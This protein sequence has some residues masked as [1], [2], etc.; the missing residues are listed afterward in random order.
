VLGITALIVPLSVK[1]TTLKREYPIMFLV[2]LLAWYL[3]SD[4]S[5]EVID[6][7]FLIVGMFVVLALV[8][9]LGIRDQKNSQEPLNSEFSDEIPTDMSTQK[10]LLWLFLGLI[11]LIA[12]SKI[13]VW[14]AVNI[15]HEFGVSDLVIGLTIIAIGTSLPELAA[16]IASALKGEHDIAI[17][18]IIGSNM[19][20]LLGVLG[21]PALIS[22]IN[23]LSET[24]LNRDYPVMI[25]LSILLFIFAY[26]FGNK[27]GKIN[28]F[29]ASILLSGYIAYMVMIYLKN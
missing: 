28:R 6:G 25:G 15:A 21:I 19:F 7:I 9:F 23:K 8:T 27:E 13:L 11:I 10:A 3:L 20:N 12:S 22:P 17:G 2:M 4:N 29:E 1:S 5:L 26:G 14:G 24:V 18:N 16:S